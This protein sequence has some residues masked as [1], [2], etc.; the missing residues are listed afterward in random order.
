MMMR[1]SSNGR[2]G[3]ENERTNERNEC[4]GER[5]GRADRRESDADV[6]LVS[7]DTSQFDRRTSYVSGRNGAQ[8]DKY[9]VCRD[10]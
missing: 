10:E 8:N 2:G 9:R 3:K 1:G 4:G 6:E 5:L 7:C